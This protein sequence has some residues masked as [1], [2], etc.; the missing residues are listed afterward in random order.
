MSYRRMASFKT[1]SDLH[2]YVRQSGIALDFDD[3]IVSGPEAPL[4]QPYRLRAAG[5]KVLPV[6]GSK[7]SPLRP[8]LLWTSLPPIQRG[9][10]GTFI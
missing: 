7:T 5:V 6:D 2:A 3:E 8:L 1:A 9:R 10:T 4:A